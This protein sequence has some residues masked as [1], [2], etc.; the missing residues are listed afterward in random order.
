MMGPRHLVEY[1]SPRLSCGRIIVARMES[2][3][4]LRGS[5]VKGEYGR[6]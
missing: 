1:D 6:R 5:F 2:A 4:K 3:L